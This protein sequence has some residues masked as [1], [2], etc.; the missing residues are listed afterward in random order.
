M[1]LMWRSRGR[2]AAAQQ[3]CVDAG[4]TGDDAGRAD[5]RGRRAGAAA[6]PRGP[7]HHGERGAEAP[8]PAA[9]IAMD[10]V[11]ARSPSQM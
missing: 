2:G 11:C 1:L 5:G 7:V 4:L 10:E 6:A 8:A 3:G 9:A